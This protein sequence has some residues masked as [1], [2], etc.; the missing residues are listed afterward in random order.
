MSL[1]KRG[2]TLFNRGTFVD[3]LFCRSAT[4]NCRGAAHQVFFSSL[5]PAHPAT[6]GIRA[7]VLPWRTHDGGQPHPRAALMSA[8]RGHGH[9]SHPAKSLIL[10]AAVGTSASG[11]SSG[12]FHME[13]IT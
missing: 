12:I 2:I 4:K 5:L 3:S 13:T 7:L 11:H 8:G 9:A 10:T 1:Q 6:H